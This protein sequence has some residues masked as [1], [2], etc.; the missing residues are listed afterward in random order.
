MGGNTA[1]A[2]VAERLWTDES[3]P[4]HETRRRWNEGQAETDVTRLKRLGRDLTTQ[5]EPRL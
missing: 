4:M 3:D 2:P 5:P 1:W